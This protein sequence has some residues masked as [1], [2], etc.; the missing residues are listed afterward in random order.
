MWHFCSQYVTFFYVLVLLFSSQYYEMFPFQS[1]FLVIFWLKEEV[2]FSGKTIK[3][4]VKLYSQNK[5]IFLCKYYLVV[6]SHLFLIVFTGN[7]P[8]ILRDILWMFRYMWESPRKEGS[9]SCTSK[10]V[11]QRINFMYVHERWNWI[12]KRR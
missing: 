9:T 4:N 1:N 8:Y 11:N 10:E 3:S 6:F 7:Y 2:P 12:E 5:M